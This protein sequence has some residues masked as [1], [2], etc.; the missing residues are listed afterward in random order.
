MTIRAVVADNPLPTTFS[1][2]FV[3][4]LLATAVHA[5]T[6]DSFATTLRLAALTAVLFLFAAGFWVGPVGERYL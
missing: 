5:S 1:L 6:A 2:A 3:L 4:A